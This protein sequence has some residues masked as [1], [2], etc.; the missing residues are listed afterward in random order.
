[1][2]TWHILLIILA[3]LAVLPA[4]Y[5]VHRLC[6]WL[7]QRGWLYYRNRRPSSSPASC[8]VALHQFLEPPV[9]HVQE[10]KEHKDTEQT[11]KAPGTGGSSVDDTGSAPQES[12]LGSRD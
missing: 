10:V 7:E 12:R 6:L 8:L 2:T 5:G 9:Q 11:S 1:M 3:A 4:L